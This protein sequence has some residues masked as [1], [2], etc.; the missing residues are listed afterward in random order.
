MKKWTIRGLVAA[1]IVAAGI[2]AYGQAVSPVPPVPDAARVAQYS[3]TSPTSTFNVP[4]P[5]YGDCSDLI[6]NVAGIGASLGPDYSCASASGRALTAIPRPITDLQVTLTNPVS[7]GTV[8]IQ[9]LF[10]PRLT[11]VPTAPGISRN[12]FNRV[13]GSIYSALRDLYQ[14]L[15]STTQQP[16]LYGIWAQ[17]VPYP[18]NAVVS[19]NNA[20]WQA[21]QANVAEAP[22]VGSPYW[23]QLT[24]SPYNYTFNNFQLPSQQTPIAAASVVDLGTIPSHFALIQGAGVQIAS[25]G[26]S[27]SSGL[28]LYWMTFANADT[29]LNSPS[30]LLP[31]GVSNINTQPGDTAVA[32]CLNAGNWQVI[33]YTPV[34]GSFI[35]GQVEAFDLASCPT[36][37]QVADGTNGTADLRGV[38]IRGLD[39]GKGLDTVRALGSYQADQLQN[40]THSGV[41]SGQGATAYGTGAYPYANPSYNGT[42]GGVVTT[43]TGI[44][45]QA[46]SETR[47]K[48]VAL[49]Y[50]QKL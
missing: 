10:R 12:E 40:H 13:I 28:P 20:I 18:P 31:N 39:L 1:V 34:A 44:V 41:Q 27:C 16:L 50:C 11:V 3:V 8:T 22:L 37:W 35:S 33:S 38:A 47:M 6:V 32:Q 24:V 30:L 21:T 7:S 14:L 46:G 45:A 23:M 49:L 5:V 25:F 43:G 36:G 2:A 42:T 15:Q 19:Y 17:T 29:L 26:S 9:S 4:F 48:N